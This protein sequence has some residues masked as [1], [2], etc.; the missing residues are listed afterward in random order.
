MIA[1]TG[2]AG[3]EVSAAVVGIVAGVGAERTRSLR[4]GGSQ[5][6]LE[7]L[8]NRNRHLGP[9]MAPLALVV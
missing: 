2:A 9:G 5:E 7:S 6:A 1:G 4:P 3:T 8:G